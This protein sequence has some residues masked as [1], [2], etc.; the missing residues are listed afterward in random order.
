MPLL[1]ATVALSALEEP[2]LVRRVSLSLPLMAVLAGAGDRKS[3]V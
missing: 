2:A 3:V 1:R